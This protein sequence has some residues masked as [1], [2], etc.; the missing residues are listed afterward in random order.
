MIYGSSKSFQ[1]Q[2]LRSIF[3][4]F[5][6]RKKDNKRDAV[7]PSVARTFR[8]RFIHFKENQNFVPL[9]IN[10]F[11]HKNPSAEE[12]LATLKFA[13]G[14]IYIT[15]HSSSILLKKDKKNFMNN[16]FLTNTYVL[17]KTVP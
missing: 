10:R 7:N 12:F 17:F 11:E 15:K 9:H 5:L 3:Y 2:R 13:F 8:R 16:F 4:L 1:V 6:K 14:S